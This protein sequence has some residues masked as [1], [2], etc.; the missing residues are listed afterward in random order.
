[1]RCV[2]HDCTFAAQLTD[3]LLAMKIKHFTLS[4]LSLLA[5]CILSA[6]QPGE[7]GSEPEPQLPTQGAPT[8]VGKPLGAPIQKT[9]GPAGGTISTPDTSVTLVIPA[10][11]LSAD[12]PISIQPTENKAWGGAGLGYELTPKNLELSKPA[13]LVWNYKDSDVT[14]SAPEALGIAYQQPDRTWKGTRKLNID[15]IKKKVAAPV[16]KLLPLAFYEAYYMDP[17]Q[18]SI[19]PTEQLQLTVFFNEGHKD[20]K[21][22]GVP[23]L[24]P[25]VLKSKD[26]KN[27]RLNGLDVNGQFDPEMGILEPGTQKA[28]A[29]YRAPNHIPKANQMA[30]SVEV[31]LPGKGKL[32]LI[33]GITV[34]GANSFSFAGAKVDSAEVATVAIV[35]GS[36]LQI[37]LSE[38]HLTEPDQAMISFSL[39]PFNGPGTYEVSDNTAVNV[40]GYDRSG[41]PWKE[42]YYPRNSTRKYGPMT[43]TILEYNK[44]SN[45]VKGI[46]SG[47]FHFYDRE[48]DKHETTQ[49]TVRFAAASPN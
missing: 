35:D 7:S 9:I 4:S 28:S 24:Q 1:M 17:D 22:E 49:L 46:I 18:S 25:T 15:I 27:W 33:S 32:I 2:C 48:K 31:V 29:Q 42:G 3:H 41:K 11:A 30:V 44:T 16:T 10:G 38:R 40:G 21:T 5:C 45:R 19:L 23:L 14:G 47:T 12:T 34:E 6:C 8:E 39:L 36:F 43:V 26:V 13:E 37:S 20:N